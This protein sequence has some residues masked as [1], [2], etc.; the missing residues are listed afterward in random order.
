VVG[1]PKGRVEFVMGVLGDR[2]RGAPQKSRFRY[3]WAMPVKAERTK[4][5]GEN[6]F[7]GRWRA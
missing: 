4:A 2:R 5:G 6:G 1:T 7:F 3:E